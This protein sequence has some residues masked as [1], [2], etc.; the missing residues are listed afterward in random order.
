MNHQVILDTGP[1]VAAI[2]QQDTYHQWTV[3]QLKQ[4]RPPLL[5]CEAVISEA[6]FLLRSHS[7]GVRAVF[8]WLCNSTIQLPFCLNKETEAVQQLITKYADVPISLADACLVRMSEIY[9]KHLILT[10][11]SDFRIYRKHGKKIIKTI[12]PDV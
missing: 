11:D 10:L 2:N 3:E 1:L 8:E 6:C 12:M 4:I 9:P 7:H 5:T